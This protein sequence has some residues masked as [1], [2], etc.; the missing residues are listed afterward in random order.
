MNLIR[1]QH[2]AEFYEWV[3]PFLL[4]FEAENNLILGMAD[5]LVASANSSP[6]PNYQ[7]LI[8]Q[9]GQIIGVAVRLLPYQVA[10]SH[11]EPALATDAIRLLA[12][13]LDS[14]YRTLPGV[15]AEA[16]LCKQFAEQWTALTGNSH[17]LF[18]PQRIYQLR[19]VNPVHGVHGTLRRANTADHDIIFEWMRDFRDDILGEPPSIEVT[20]AMV[21]DWLNTASHELYLWEV[22]ADPVSMAG[23]NYP[24][25]HG[26][27]ISA[28]YTP[29]AQRRRGYASACVA[30]LSQL[31]LDRGRQ[32]C[33]LYTDVTNPTANHIYQEIG[34]ELI[35]DADEYRF[36]HNS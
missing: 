35:C 17:L 6:E 16:S 25:P 24:T 20:E 5:E 18:R 32:F 13:D 7:A 12:H 30:S 22:G 19:Q 27:R 9:N 10:I 4:D 29:P 15:L 28:V 11:I 14:V 31:Q 3:T 2:A 33:F 23:I 21:S 26:I 36:N 34:Y 1:F 8:E